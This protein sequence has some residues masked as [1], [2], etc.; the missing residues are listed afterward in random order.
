MADD[1]PDDEVGYNV[2]YGKPP[3]HSRF[4][5]GVSA[6]PKGRPKG[7][8]NFQTEINEELRVK[9]TI[10]ENGRRKQIT[11]RRAIAKQI[12]NKSTMGDL[13]AIP[14]L[15]NETR[16]KNADG[17]GL[18]AIFDTADD[19]AVM[20]SLIQRLREQVEPTAVPAPNPLKQS[21]SGESA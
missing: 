16:D 11:K 8:R 13:K 17:S 2:G 19:K 9:I 4:K 10:N 18:A 1:N 5:P 20:A 21:D 7:V 3:L 6:N 15:L 14:V 12:V